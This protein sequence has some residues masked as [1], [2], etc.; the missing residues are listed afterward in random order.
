ML[1][2]LSEHCDIGPGSGGCGCCTLAHSIVSASNS[3][4]EVGSTFVHR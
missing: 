2:E 3:I 4:D 1:G